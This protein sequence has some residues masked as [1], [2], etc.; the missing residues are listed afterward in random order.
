MSKNTNPKLKLPFPL[1][2]FSKDRHK[3]PFRYL[4]VVD[5][6]ATCDY[7]PKPE[8]DVRTAEIIEVPWLVFDTHTGEVIHERQIYV[9]PDKLDAVTS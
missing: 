3:C 5:F 6:E 9:C 4:V 7:G 2:P 8:V 1:P